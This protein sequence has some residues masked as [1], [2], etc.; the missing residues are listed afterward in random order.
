MPGQPVDVPGSSHIAD[1][2][3]PNT[4]YTH[5]HVPEPH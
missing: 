2:L 3:Y 5:G 4:T 1:I